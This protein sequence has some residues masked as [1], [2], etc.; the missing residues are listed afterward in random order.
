MKKI[1]GAGL[2]FV[3]CLTL[4]ATANAGVVTGWDMRNVT[5]TPGPYTL[6]ETYNSYLF[7]DATKLE[8]AV[9]QNHFNGHRH[10]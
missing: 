5:V 1:I 8:G 9:L 10:C 4:A 2:A 3:G 7:T 6:Y